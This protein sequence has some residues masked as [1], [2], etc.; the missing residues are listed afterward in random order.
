MILA[1]AKTF[2]TLFRTV[3]R[4][5][6]D[7]QTSG[8][9]SHRSWPIWKC[10]MP[11]SRVDSSS[12][13]PSHGITPTAEVDFTQ[14]A[15]AFVVLGVVRGVRR[16]LHC[17]WHRPSSH[18]NTSNCYDPTDS[19]RDG[20][21]PERARPQSSLLHPQ[22]G[23]CQAFLRRTTYVRYGTCRTHPTG[24]FVSSGQRRPTAPPRLDSS[25][26]SEW[27]PPESAGPC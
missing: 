24:T 6:I 4:I 12:H 19:T 7:R 22:S 20:A 21:T 5:E 16:P 14:I 18:R 26:P 27:R 17:A 13:S 8:I 10:V 9:L 23:C 15:P 11:G 1:W 2:E 3:H 25:P